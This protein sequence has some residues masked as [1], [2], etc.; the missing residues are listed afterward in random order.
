MYVGVYMYI[1]TYCPYHPFKPPVPPNLTISNSRIH[2][3]KPI[4]GPCQPRSSLDS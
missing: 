2:V 4:L 3:Q 1:Y